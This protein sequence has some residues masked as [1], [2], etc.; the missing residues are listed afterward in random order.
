MADNNNGARPQA[1]AE[2][3][4]QPQEC[5][6]WSRQ[7]FVEW[8]E[9][10][11]NNFTTLITEG[12]ANSMTNGDRLVFAE[13]RDIF[14]LSVS[15]LMALATSCLRAGQAGE[16]PL[17]TLRSAVIAARKLYGRLAARLSFGKTVA[18]KFANIK[19]EGLPDADVEKMRRAADQDKRKQ[20]QDKAKAGRGRGGYRGGGNRRFTPYGQRPNY[21]S[22]GYQQMGYAPMAPH[23]PQFQFPSQPYIPAQPG[24]QGDDMKGK[25]HSCG[26]QV[27]TF[28]FFLKSKSMFCLS[29]SLSL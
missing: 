9:N 19:I 6:G 13:A 23:Y 10:L 17:K 27:R 18:D 12:A 29:G 21:Q 2:T 3:A 15:N 11:R 1:P 24:P 16:Q 4:E 20:E 28:Y 26:L 7:R 14:I 5:E 8:S 25:C 22:Y